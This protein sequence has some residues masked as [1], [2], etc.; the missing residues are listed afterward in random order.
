MRRPSFPLQP[1]EESFF[2]TAP[3]R[4]RETFDVRRPASQ[5]W[6]DLTGDD[7]RTLYRYYRHKTRPVANAAADRMDGLLGQQRGS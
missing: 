7:P 3:F 1:I 6:A 5:V 4:L 2:D